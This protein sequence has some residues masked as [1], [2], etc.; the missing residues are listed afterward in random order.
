MRVVLLRRLPLAGVGAAAGPYRLLGLVHL[1]MFLQR[2][3][4]VFAE[5]VRSDGLL[6]DL[7]QRDHQGSCRCRA[8]RSATKPLAIMRARWPASR[9]ELEPVL[10]LVDAIFHG[11]ARHGW[12]PET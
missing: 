12:S 6:G 10:D 9:H 3:D 4:E 1:D 8:A 2:V 5:I 7:A 11:H